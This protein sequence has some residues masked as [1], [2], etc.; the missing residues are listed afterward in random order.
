MTNIQ[1]VCSFYVC[2]VSS[3][4]MHPII[5]WESCWSS[6]RR[7]NKDQ[8]SNSHWSS[9]K[10]GFQDLEHF[11]RDC[12]CKPKIRARFQTCNN[13]QRRSLFCINCSKT[14]KHECHSSSTALSF[15]YRY[16]NFDTNCPKLPSRC[17]SVCLPTNGVYQVNRKSSS[18]SQ[19]VDD[20]ACA[21]EKK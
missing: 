16:H 9:I 6:K 5:S 21:L 1:Q 20:R 18:N 15:G 4:S 17:M 14:P 8:C 12:K 10:C 13:A 11:L 2:D 7:S 19:G 3:N